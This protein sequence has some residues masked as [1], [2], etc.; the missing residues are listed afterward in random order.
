MHWPRSVHCSRACMPGVLLFHADGRCPS[1][2]GI[3]R[4]LPPECFVVHHGA[5]P[6]ISNKV[7]PCWA[8]ALA[9]AGM[10]MAGIVHQGWVDPCLGQSTWFRH[11]SSCITPQ[12]DV[13]SVGVIFY[14]M[15]FGRRPFGHEQSQEQILRNEVGGREQTE[16]VAEDKQN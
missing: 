16:L 10:R 8:A 3:C 15:L 11:R 7:W 9:Q 6:I 12:V 5:A 2:A 14:Q 1:L 4:Y 13:W